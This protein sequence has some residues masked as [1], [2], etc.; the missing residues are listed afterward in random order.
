MLESGQM[1]GDQIMQKPL[2]AR[3]KMTSHRLA[4]LAVTLGIILALFTTDAGHRPRQVSAG[5]NPGGGMTMH[6]A[7]DASPEFREIA[8]AAAQAM[9]D[10]DV[11]GAAIAIYANGREEIATFGVEDVE[12]K[13][14]V[15]TATRFEMGSV[16]KTYTAT[17]VMRLVDLGLID[18]DATVRTYIPEFRVADPEASERVTIRNLL[19]HTSGWW[20]DAF[21]DTG[22]DDKALARLVS[23]VYPSLPQLFPV[24]T[25][26]SYNNVAVALLGR[27]TEVVTGK[28]Y[29]SALNDLVLQPLGLSSATFDH[30][31]VLT[32]H[33]AYGHVEGQ[34]G[35]EHVTPLF[36]PRSVEPAGNMWINIEDQIRY[37][38]YQMGDP[39]VG[40]PAVLKPETRELMQR[41]QRVVVGQ[42][43]ASIGLVWGISTGDGFH[44]VDHS[45]DPFGEA[46]KISFI[47][48]KQVGLVVLTNSASGAAVRQVV[49]KSVLQRYVGTSL[50]SGIPADASTQAS[51]SP[52]WAEDYAGVYQQPGVDILVKSVDGKPMAE[53]SLKPPPGLI[54]EAHDESVPLT[55]LVFVGRDH[56]VLGS[57]ENP[58]AHLVFIRRDDGSIGWVTVDARVYIRAR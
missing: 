32:G 29:R 51:L 25:Q 21:Y 33:Y 3:T 17:A 53:L 50:P 54:H 36:L 26:L 5:V 23:D 13:A 1:K 46:S 35:P 47:P 55:P 45:G 40:A 18:L 48:E 44:I 9:K 24:G 58:F 6:I 15:T 34:S 16:T 37:V 42:P 43:G 27:I 28:P 7:A 39:Y 2:E 10:A 38:R 11:P 20:G 31:V 19:T 8:G 52:R 30:D 57:A 12:T 4:A 49:L 41:P 56:A 14:P 22:E